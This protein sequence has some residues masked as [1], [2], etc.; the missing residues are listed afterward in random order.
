MPESLPAGCPI[1]TSAGQWVFAP[2]RGFSQLVTSFVA[3]ESPGIPHA[4]FLF[5]FYLPLVRP[6]PASRLCESEIRHFFA[7]W[8]LV[9]K[10]FVFLLV[11]SRCARDFHRS[12]S[13]PALS[14]FSLG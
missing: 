12:R 8:L 1:R 7:L 2:R 5:R 9:V 13:L 4:P 10:L 11:F 6:E 3:S 14:M